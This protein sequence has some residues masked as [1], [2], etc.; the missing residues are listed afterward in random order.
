[1]HGLDGLTLAPGVVGAGVGL[2]EVVSPGLVTTVVS[3]S[4]LKSLNKLTG[5]SLKIKRTLPSA[6]VIK[7]ALALSTF[8]APFKPKFSFQFP[9]ITTFQKYLLLDFK[10]SRT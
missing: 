10:P 5:F 7:S 2:G 4:K 3:G 9:S 1:M 6:D 8:K